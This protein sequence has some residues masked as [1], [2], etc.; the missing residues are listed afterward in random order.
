MLESLTKIIACGV[1]RLEK[2][3]YYVVINNNK[4]LRLVERYLLCTHLFGLYQ[5]NTKICSLRLMKTLV[6]SKFTM[7]EMTLI[8]GSQN[9]EIK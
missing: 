1:N 7:T 5:T 4:R 9:F 6:T 2:F 8:K 3:T